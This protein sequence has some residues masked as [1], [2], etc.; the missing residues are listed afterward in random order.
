MTNLL[1][2]W[3]G[4]PTSLHDPSLGLNTIPRS[5]YPR[6]NVGFLFFLWAFLNMNTLILL[7]WLE[8]D[9]LLLGL[10]SLCLDIIRLVLCSIVIQG[11]TPTFINDRHYPIGLSQR[12]LLD[13]RSMRMPL[14]R[15]LLLVYFCVRLILALKKS[16][17]QV[18][19]FLI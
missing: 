4:L 19:L 13:N 2:Y 18:L 7:L 6:C 12:V 14:C 16:R 11:Q 10:L 1:I 17:L 5:A 15:F 3:T 9:I 8:R